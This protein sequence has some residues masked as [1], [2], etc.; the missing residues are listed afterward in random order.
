[1]KKLRAATEAE[2]IAEFLKNEFYRKEFHRDRVQF[3][4]LVLHGDIHNEDE[5]VLR[6]ALLFRRRGH[7][8]RELPADTLWWEVQLEPQDLERVRVFPRAHWRKIS[9]GSF[10][11]THIVQRIRAGNF[12]GKVGDFISKIHSL[13]YGLHNDAEPSSVIL[14]GE[15]VN[16]SVTIIEG[17]HRMT[18][19]LL[20]SADDVLTRFRVFIG[21]S[22]SMNEVCW[23]DHSLA[24]LL[25][26]ARNRFKSL[27]HDQDGDLKRLHTV[28]PAYSGVSAPGKAIPE[29]K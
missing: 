2:V 17:N 28:P 3:E 23:H 6:R 18:A 7:L 29:P 13:S 21:T 20:G 10:G 4:H 26:Y 5:N 22:P 8:W 19:A 27:W 15:N 14:I 16:Q 25:R 12:S 1:M 11:L 9:N 24:N